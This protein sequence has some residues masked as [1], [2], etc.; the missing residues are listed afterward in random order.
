MTHA[1]VPNG[2]LCLGIKIMATAISWDSL[3]KY[4]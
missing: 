2:I 1:V 3:K 4:L